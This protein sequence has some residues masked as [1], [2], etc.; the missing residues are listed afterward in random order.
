M[1]RIFILSSE[2]AFKSFQHSIEA[3]RKG[4]MDDVRKVSQYEDEVDTLE[5]EL[6]ES[7][8]SGCLPANVILRQAWCSWISS[9]I[10]A[11]F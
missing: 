11:Y 7:I 4:D 1:S 6:R 8:L 3:R 10:W 5:E 2:T 9:A